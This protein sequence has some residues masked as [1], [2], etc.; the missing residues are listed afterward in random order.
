M[1]FTMSRS[2]II[3]IGTQLAKEVF[4]GESA[5]SIHM[6]LIME[7]FTRRLADRVVESIE[8]DAE[9]NARYRS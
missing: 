4:P 3:E 8:A 9:Y 6:R 2:E 5:T 7:E 1:E